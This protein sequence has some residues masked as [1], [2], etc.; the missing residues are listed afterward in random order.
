MRLRHP[1]RWHGFALAAA[2]LAAACGGAPA[3]APP[4]LLLV[5]IDTLRADSLGAYGAAPSAT[6]NLDRLASESTLF[7]RALAPMP[8]TR[9]AHFSMLTARYPREHGVLNNRLSL[10]ES[11]TTLAERLRAAGFRTGAFVGVALLGP[12]SGAERGFEALGTPRH[13]HREGAEVVR[14]ALAWLRSVPSDEPFFLWVHLFDPHLPY[15]PPPELRA[16]LDPELAERLPSVG[17]KDL[18]AEARAHGGDVPR[19]VLEHARRLYAGEVASI[20]RFVGELLL[21]VEAA[22]AAEELAVVFTADHGECF[23]GGVYFEHS[24]C[25]RDGALRV[26][27]FVR[28]ASFPPGLRVGTPVSHVDLA[29]TLLRIAGLEVP[30]GLSGRPLQELLA[31]DSERYVLVQYPLYQREIEGR[32]GRQAAIRSVAGDPVA[33]ILVATERVGIAGARWKYLRTLQG[34]A[35]GGDLF[36]VG[37]RGE[38]PAALADLPPVE[39][40][41][42]AA[43]LDA[44]LAEHPLRLLEPGRLQPELLET[45]RALGYAE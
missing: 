13:R 10:P 19:A 17:W 39:R 41:E 12:G 25:L 24:D 23:E 16:G 44:L 40:E 9:P 30:V 14:E 1:R 43:R 29:P 28:H 5:T 27:L 2:W 38:E 37:E 4:S 20:D 3:A 32:L 34:E 15:A 18:E 45:L 11:E 31:S 36:A 21:G 33:P 8:L 42:L 6:P 26:P 22:R 7:L 35:G